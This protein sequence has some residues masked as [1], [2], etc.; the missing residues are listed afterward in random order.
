VTDHSD[1]PPVLIRTVRPDDDLDAQL[2]LAERSFGPSGP[3]GRAG[4]RQRLADRITDGRTVGAF[5]GDRPAGTATFHDMRQWWC[6]RAV[7]MAGVAGVMVAPED[8][9]RGVARRLIAALLDE[10]S[11]RGYPLSALYPATMPLYRRSAGN[12]PAPGPPPW[13]RRGPCATWCRPIRPPR[14]PGPR[15]R[16]CAGPWPVTPTR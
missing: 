7:P 11:A 16:G 6:G 3:A 5:D 14:P 13:F 1:A 4:R 10:V 12:W 9:G 8:R 2:D 15:P